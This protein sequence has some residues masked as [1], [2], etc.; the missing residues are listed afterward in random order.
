M[1]RRPALLPRA[2]LARVAVPIG[3]PPRPAPRRGGGVYPYGNATPGSSKWY[4]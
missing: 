2:P 3:S 4:H 1:S